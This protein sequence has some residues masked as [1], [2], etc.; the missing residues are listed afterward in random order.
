MLW[1]FR[2]DFV[3][4][5]DLSKHTSRSLCRCV[6]NALSDTKDTLLSFED[7]AIM[8]FLLDYLVV[9]TSIRTPYTN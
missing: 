6:S 8:N 5:I 4:E 9:S 2:F 3:I 1:K 7:H